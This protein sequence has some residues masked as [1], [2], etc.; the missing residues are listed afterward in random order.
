MNQVKKIIQYTDIHIGA[1]HQIPNMCYAEIIAEFSKYKNDP[2]VLV[3]AT[4][5]IFDMT[6]CRDSMAKYYTEQMLYMKSVMGKYYKMGNH[7]SEI[8][9]DGYTSHHEDIGWFHDHVPDWCNS[10]T[11]PCKKVVKWENKGQGKSKL[12]YFAY[13]FKHKVWKRGRDWKPTGEEI[14]LFVDYAKA[15]NLKTLCM[16]HTHKFF[17]QTFDGVRIINGGRGRTEYDL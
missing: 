1:P 10:M 2:T 13:R 3:I 14:K 6:N 16:G 7:E 4:G 15:N 11:K 17:D 9:E 5:D 8:D 12:R